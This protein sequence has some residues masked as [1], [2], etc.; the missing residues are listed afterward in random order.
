[1]NSLLLL[2]LITGYL[3]PPT[4]Y[5]K[6]RG[7]QF[8]YTQ[9]ENNKE[10]FRNQFSRKQKSSFE[11]ERIYSHF[12]TWIRNTSKNMYTTGFS[13]NLLWVVYTVAYAFIV[14]LMLSVL[15]PRH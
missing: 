8:I 9:L 7:K 3:F 6:L 11:K 1:M 14:N 5:Y 4:L 2:T 12:N 10:E 13:L 15:D